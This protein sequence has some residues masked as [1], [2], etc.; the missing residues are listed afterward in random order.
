MIQPSY[1]TPVSV[2]EPKTCAN[3]EKYSYSNH[4]QFNRKIHR[5]IFK[6]SRFMQ[7]R[8]FFSDLQ[9][10]LI[11]FKD[12]Y[13]II[14]ATHEA[15]YTECFAMSKKPFNRKEKVSSFILPEILV[16][17]TGINKITM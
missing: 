15:Q 1:P 5:G 17:N 10:I 8:N 16:K 14:R 9:F 12:K 7:S 13:L 2:L 6:I 4:L 11:V 3:I